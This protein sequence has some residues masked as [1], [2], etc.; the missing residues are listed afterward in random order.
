[1]NIPVPEF[2]NLLEMA[3]FL[4]FYESKLDFLG[5]GERKNLDEMLI[6]FNK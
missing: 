4:K 6:K 5:E 2:S 1:M 3:H